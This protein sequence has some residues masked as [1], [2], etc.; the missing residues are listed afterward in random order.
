M[1]WSPPG[2][3]E[4]KLVSALDWP[5]AKTLARAPCWREVRGSCV[6][7]QTHRLTSTCSTGTDVS[8]R[9]TRPSGPGP[10][11]CG[12]HCGISGSVLGGPDLLVRAISRSRDVRTSPPG[13]HLLAAR[14]AAETARRRSCSR[15]VAGRS[16]KAIGNQNQ[17]LPAV[18][19]IQP[20]ALKLALP[21]RESG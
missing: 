9:R 10:E 12:S 7:L 19:R 6:L 13:T 17:L 1:T 20:P 3:A 4:P 16:R 5:S 11:T 21:S 18:N 15:E 14:L 2:S 8:H